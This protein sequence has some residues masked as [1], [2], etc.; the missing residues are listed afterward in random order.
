MKITENFIKDVRAMIR[1]NSLIINSAQVTR[2]KIPKM[3]GFQTFL[4]RYVKMTAEQQ[5]EFAP[6]LKRR[7][8]RQ[9]I[10]MYYVKK[11]THS[12]MQCQYYNSYVA[13]IMRSMFQRMNDIPGDRSVPLTPK[14]SCIRAR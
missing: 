12:D 2:R 5:L 11:G 1:Y 14:M 9:N 4:K 3:V 8:I 6:E 7:M 13:P 10:V